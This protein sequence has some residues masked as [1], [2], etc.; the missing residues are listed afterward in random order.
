MTVTIIET[1]ENETLADY[2]VA[3]LN[4]LVT[5]GYFTLQEDDGLVDLVVMGM[6]TARGFATIRRALDRVCRDWLDSRLDG[7]EPTDA[8]PGQYLLGEHHFVM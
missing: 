5:G 1:I 4:H 2:A 6:P 8:N 7:S 3:A